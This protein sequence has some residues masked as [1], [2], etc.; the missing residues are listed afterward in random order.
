LNSKKNLCRLLCRILCRVPP[1]RKTDKGS[2]EGG[3]RKGNCLAHL[4]FLFVFCVAFTAHAQEKITYQ[5]HVLPLIENNC[6][7]CHN[8]DKKKADLDLTS[9]SGVI[10]G[11]G[12]GP[13]VVAGNPDSSKLWKAITQV[14]EP[15]MPPN[16]PKLPDKELEI[17]RKWIAGGLLETTGS[18]AIAASKPAVDF[19]LKAGSVGKPDGPPA[20]PQEL[21]LDPVVHTAHANPLTAL[22]SSPWAPLIALAGQK[23]ILLYHSDTLELLGILPFT[24]GQ[25]ADVK[26]SR[27]GTLLLAGGGRGGKS[28]RV[29]VW[30]VV[31]GER[32]M[33]I[34]DEY[35]TVIA[36]DIRPDQSQIALGGPGRLV[37]I[38]STKSGELLHKKKK[39]TDWVNALAFSPSGALLASGDRNGGITI[40]DPDNGQELFTLAGHKAAVSALSWRG[41]S[42]L[43]ASCSEDGAVKLWE[44]QDGKQAKTWEAHKGGALSVAYT[45]DGRLVS[46]GRDNQII[47]WNADGT[48]VRSLAFSGELPLRAIFNHDG[49]RVFATD[50]AGHAAAWKTDDGKRIGEIDPNP[51]PL[52]EQ[53]AAAEKRIAELQKNANKPSPNLA[54]AEAELTQATAE[55]D[56]AS[57]VVEEARSEQT[58][59]ENAVVHLKEEAAKPSPP[60]DIAAKLE[61]ARAVR[62]KTR[63]ATTNTLEVMQARAKDVIVAKEKLAQAKLDNPT[64]ELASL[65]A[66]VTKLKAGQVQSSVYRARES[67]ATKKREQEKLL[68]ISTEKQEELKRL[69]EELNAASDAASKS[70][71]KAALKTATAEAKAADAAAKKCITELASEQAR[72]DKLTADYKRVKTALLPTALP[73]KLVLGNAQS[74]NR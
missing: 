54:A 10:K 38:Y 36:A 11:S 29:L 49:S 5:D 60:G 67:L 43:L 26:F 4:I 14:E 48:K 69:T 44:M 37:K 46:C 50:F 24:E 8:P 59:R 45:H 55:M 18:K 31:T 70:K 27:N 65:T 35:D 28:G 58:A 61:T 1:P 6:G 71:L 25:P 22:A 9:Y 17:F 51:L 57:K 72:F 20:M 2:D 16:K 21:P 64:E 68:A 52:S 12:S 19:T 56:R 33:T 3:I 7:K 53:L 32:L 62:A 39:H 73:S 74:L 15:T 40:W 30:N 63:Q 66:A 23:Q 13:V 47:M 41:D 34:G 42:K